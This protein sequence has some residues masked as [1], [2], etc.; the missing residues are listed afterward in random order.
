MHAL[1]LTSLSALALLACSEAT[2]PPERDQPAPA[3]VE[4]A[5]AN[6]NG[7]AWMIRDDGCIA[8]PAV[9]ADGN[10]FPFFDPPCSVHV[11]DTRNGNGNA[12]A[13]FKGTTVNEFGRAV[14]A[15]YDPVTAPIMC[16]FLTASGVVF[17]TKVQFTITPKG[18]VSGVCHVP[19]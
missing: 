14:Q 9:D 12:H 4:T 13:V 6:A 8:L 18:K 5:V 19:D 15:R 11:I 3:Q 2:A 10:I 16:S 7:G 17:T 1:R